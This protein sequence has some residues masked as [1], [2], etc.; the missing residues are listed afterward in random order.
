MEK[1]QNHP[2]LVFFCPILPGFCP[3]SSKNHSLSDSDFITLASP[4]RGIASLKP[5]QSKI[6]KHGLQTNSGVDQN[7]QQI[8]YW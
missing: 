2:V 5:K 8:E 4:L 7:G 1:D 6:E 3:K